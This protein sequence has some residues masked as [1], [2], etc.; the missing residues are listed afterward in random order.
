MESGLH[1]KGLPWP[2][3]IAPF[4]VH[5]L[6]LAPEDGDVNG[7]A[8]NM[9]SSLQQD[10]WEVLHDERRVRPGVKFKDAELLGLSYLVVV[11]SRSLREGVV[12]VG[13]CG[14]TDRE[15]IKVAEVGQVLRD[16]TNRD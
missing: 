11:G 10:G 7:A 5:L 4:D 16:W 14:D 1:E 13:R 15:K 6:N 12:E 2:Q 3:P 8:Q 9:T